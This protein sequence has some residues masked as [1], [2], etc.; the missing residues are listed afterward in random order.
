MK[1]GNNN[2]T[3]QCNADGKTYSYD[4]NDPMGDILKT[5]PICVFFRTLDQVEDRKYDLN[6]DK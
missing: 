4:G 2:R 3:P 1:N 5:A 6:C